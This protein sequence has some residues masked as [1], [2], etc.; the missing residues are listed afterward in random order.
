M[1]K[2]LIKETCINIYSYI[3]IEGKI[4]ILSVKKPNVLMKGICKEVSVTIVL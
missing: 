4:F 3:N 1:P 2:V